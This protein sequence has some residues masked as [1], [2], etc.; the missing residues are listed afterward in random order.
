MQALSHDITPEC[1]TAA[2]AVRHFRGQWRAVYRAATPRGL[3]LQGDLSQGEPPSP[4]HVQDQLSGDR[5]V[6][7]GKVAAL[8][9]STGHYHLYRG[10]TAR[11]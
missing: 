11:C 5:A 1:A 4:E 9:E 7:I 3:P 10:Q 8:K 2:S 6:G